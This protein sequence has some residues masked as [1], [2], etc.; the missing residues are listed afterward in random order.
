MADADHQHAETKA[1]LW[2]ELAALRSQMKEKEEVLI[3][4]HARSID[5]VAKLDHYEVL[6][7]LAKNR[8]QANED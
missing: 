4:E 5:V 2:E 8:A 1:K 7:C 6:H 3:K